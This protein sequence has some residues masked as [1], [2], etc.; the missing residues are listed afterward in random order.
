MQQKPENICRV[1]KESHIDNILRNKKDRLIVLVFSYDDSSLRVFMKRHLAVNNPECY[2]VLAHVDVKGEKKFNFEVDRG[3]YIKLLNGSTIPFPF[4]VFFHDNK[5]LATIRQASPQTILEELDKLKMLLK[6]D[7]IGEQ[8]K[9]N[10][11]YEYQ[12]KKMQDLKKLN[13]IGELEKIQKLK[14]EQEQEQEH[15]DQDPEPEQEQQ[16]KKRKEKKK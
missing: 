5:C 12:I 8:V 15:N 11:A 7:N 4:V 3:T 9:Q 2:F 14:E 10:M 6:K 1:L 16:K 13:E